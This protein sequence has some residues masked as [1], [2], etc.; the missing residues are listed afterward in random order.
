[1]H[2]RDV[3]EVEQIIDDQFIVR[4][5]FQ[6]TRTGNVRRRPIVETTVIGDRR[7]IG[8]LVAHPDP[9]Q[10]MTLDDGIAFEMQR[11]RN[12]ALAMRILDAMPVGAKLN[13]VIYAL[14]PI[15]RQ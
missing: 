9:D 3:A 4:S 1:M 2:I 15:A 12:D 6:I 14:Y 8:L 11:T 10:R 5:N 13:S 7:R